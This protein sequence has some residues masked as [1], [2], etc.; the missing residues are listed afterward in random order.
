MPRI[1]FPPDFCW[2]AA[3]AAHQVEGNNTNSDWWAWEQQVGRIKQSHKSGLACDWWAHAEADFDRAAQM[4]LNALRLSVEW[5][6]IEPRPGEFDSAALERYAEMLRGL[7]QRGIEPMVTLHHFSNPLWLAERGAWEHPKTIGLF[8]RF[9]R[10][11]VEV[12]EPYCDLWCTINEVNVYGYASYVDG[13][14]PPG[15]KSLPLAMQVIRHMLLGHAAAYHEIHAVQP[16]ARVGLAHNMRTMDPANPRSLLDRF[17]AWLPSRTFN[18]L[19]L[20]ALTEG[21]WALP[22]G[23]GAVPEMRGTADWFG[24]NY[25]C[26]S[27]VAFDLRHSKT[28]FAHQFCDEQCELLDG[29][30]GEYYPEGLYRFLLRL[31]ELDIPLYV[32]ENGCPDL[33]DDLR[34]R[35]LVEHLYQIWRAIQAGCPVQGYYH[36]TLVDNFEWAEGWTLPFG[37]IE[38]DP[39][40][41]MRTMRRSGEIYGEIV[42]AGGI[43]PEIVEQYTLDLPS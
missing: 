26:R 1:V 39:E 43:P 25:Y 2:G 35:Y 11:V 41:Q 34:P 5:S 9:V 12:L 6:R 42:Q 20:I 24:L 17:A 40:T 36:W 15:K 13:L 18:E 32:T 29:D 3:V 33:D 8:A 37:L 31:Q 28:L 7:R 38:L 19:L 21:R 14:F 22:L 10:R 23:L 4:G 30:Y 27:H 16:Q